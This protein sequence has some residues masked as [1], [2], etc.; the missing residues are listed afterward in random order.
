MR[1]L[2]LALLLTTTTAFGAVPLKWFDVATLAGG[3]SNSIT[4]S[5]DVDT[6]S[7]PEP[8]YYEMLGSWL[9]RPA[10]TKRWSFTLEQVLT[11]RPAPGRLHISLP[12]KLPGNGHFSFQLRNCV[13]RPPD[14]PQCTSWAN[15]LDPT[16]ARVDGLPRAWWVYGHLEPPGGVIPLPASTGPTH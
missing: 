6:T 9:E 14:P 3:S 1:I 12:M 13:N 2:L 5:W 15:T 7:G 16:V 4:L 11:E 8:D 10:S